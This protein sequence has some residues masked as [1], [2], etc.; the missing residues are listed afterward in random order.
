MQSVSIVEPDAVPTVGLG[1]YYVGGAAAEGA[2][3]NSLAASEGQEVPNLEAN[4]A[5]AAT[6]A[7]M[8]AAELEAVI[9][10]SKRK[11]GSLQHR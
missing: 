8:A 6:P 3:S 7:E 10:E 9:A 1:M 4:S 2:T 11:T 5:P